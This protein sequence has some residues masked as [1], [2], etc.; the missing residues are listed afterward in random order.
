[1]VLCFAYRTTPK[2]HGGLRLCS[3]HSF[4]PFG[5]CWVFVAVLG[6]SLVVTSRGYSLL[7]CAQASH[8]DGFSCCGVGSRQA[9]FIF[10][11]SESGG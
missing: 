4:F 10:L 5:L 1:M 3:L 6:L 8:C 11:D 2:G 9:G 7:R